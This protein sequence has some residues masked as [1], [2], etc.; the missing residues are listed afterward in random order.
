LLFECP[1]FGKVWS[2]FYAKV[3]AQLLSSFDSIMQWVRPR[4]KM[5]ISLRN[6]ACFP[7]DSKYELETM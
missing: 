3:L 5:L 1:Y 7:G 4:L 6:L 2:Y